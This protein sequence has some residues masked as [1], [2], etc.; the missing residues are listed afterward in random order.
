MSG[1]EFQIHLFIESADSQMAKMATELLETE[2]PTMQRLKV[3]VKE[4]KNSIWYRQKKEYRKMANFKKE[5]FCEPCNTKSECWGPCGICGR[6]N[7]QKEF[8]KFKDKAN[9]QNAN[10]VN[11]ATNKKKKKKT[12]KKAMEI[13]EAKRDSTEEAEDESSEEDSQK[14]KSFSVRAARVGYKPGP[15]STEETAPARMR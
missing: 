6:R 7:H 8:C 1:N 14:K 2:N 10:R 9:N 11:K 13:T 3:K 5:K 4:T 15:N 12:S